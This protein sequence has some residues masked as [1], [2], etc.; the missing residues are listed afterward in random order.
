MDIKEF[1]KDS[2]RYTRVMDLRV[3]GVLSVLSIIAS[4]LLIIVGVS[5]N[6]NNTTLIVYGVMFLIFSILS[7]RRFI[8][9]YVREE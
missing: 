6:N 8:K 3:Y 4:L 5:S 9:A 1:I 7:I 2:V